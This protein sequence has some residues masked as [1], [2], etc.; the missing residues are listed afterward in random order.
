MSLQSA[1]NKHNLSGDWTISGV[2]K[3]LDSLS[4]A[5][6]NLESRGNKKLLVDCG[7]INSIDMTGLQLLH[8]WMECARIRGVKP[9]LI[10]LPVDMRHM[11]QPLG[12]LGQYLEES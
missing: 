7:N 5:L 12:L 4:H 11:I 9:Q 1:V 10:N 6:Q 2:V 3:Q 8:V